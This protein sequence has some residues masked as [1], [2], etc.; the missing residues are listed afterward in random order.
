MNDQP[1]ALDSIEYRRT[2]GL[3]ATGVTILLART[4]DGESIGMTA[5]SL[6]SVSL[7]P[8]LLLVCVAKNAHIA[9][10]LL[11]AEW[12]SLS[13]LCEEQASLSDYFAGIYP[14]S[15]P[16][17]FTFEE[18][19]GGL[20]IIGAAGAIG[21]KRGAVIEGG[22]HWIVMGEVIALHRRDDPPDPLIFYAGKYRQL[23]DWEQ[24]H[25]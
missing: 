25:L 15:E 18:W 14:G 6:T 13:I 3:F 5:N 22:D 19:T 21:C 8:L 2:M 17:E 12:F 11:K 10:H 24:D 4:A 16:P 9:E 20:R 7:N 23:A 1:N